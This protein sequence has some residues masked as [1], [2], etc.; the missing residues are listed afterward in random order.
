ML[1]QRLRS[2]VTL[3]ETDVAVD[4]VLM[5][6]SGRSHLGFLSSLPKAASK[7]ISAGWFG[8]QWIDVSTDPP[9]RARRS[10][11]PPSAPPLSFLE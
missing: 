3:R 2:A 7:C 11:V 8:G 4:L 9:D 5:H 6:S 10:P 1:S